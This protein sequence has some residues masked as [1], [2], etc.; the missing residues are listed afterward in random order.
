[1]QR[2]FGLRHAFD[3]PVTVGITVGVAAALALAPA[4]MAIAI[5]LQRPDDQR[6]REL[7][8]RY[9]SWLVMA[10]LLLGPVLLGAATTILGVAVLSLLCYREYARATGLFRERAISAM[11][12][13]GIG[14]V[15]FAVADHYYGMFVAMGPIVVSLIAAV[16]I[17]A[18][19]PQG[20]IQRVALGAL[21]YLLF[22]VG[23]GHLG[24]MAND[25]DYR[26]IVLTVV[27]CV[28]L[29][30]VFAYVCGRTMGRRKLAPMTSPNK[31]LA[32]ALGALVLTTALYAL[33]GRFLFAGSVLAD[34]VHLVVLGAIISMTGQFGD[35]MLSSIKR[36]LGIKDIGATI[37]GHGG[38]LDRSDSLLLAAPAVFHYVHYFR[39]FG[40]DQ[41]TR[42]ISG[43]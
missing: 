31:T 30:D 39:G 21:G 9:R 36:D 7:W 8:T 42:I 20:Y 3:H 13:A 37:P 25:A 23:L 26:P 5:R 1:M 11:V 35:L 28:E 29:N 34:P 17:L 15:T 10:P 12:V 14:L 19:R 41:A 22:G 40:L 33:I 2:L 4:L 32:G 6:R 24:Y 38:L 16:A 43:G 18:D 27:I